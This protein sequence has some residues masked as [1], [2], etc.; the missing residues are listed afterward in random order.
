MIYVGGVD[1]KG[2]EI[3]VRDPLADQLKAAHDASDDKVRALLAVSEVF[4]SDLPKAPRFVDAVS[5]A[6]A[7]LKAYGAQE[8]VRRFVG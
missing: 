7:S 4:G 3:D 6:F 2:A 5:E 8:T 1:E